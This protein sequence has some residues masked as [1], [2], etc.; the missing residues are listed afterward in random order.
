MRIALATP[1]IMRTNRDKRL[2]LEF[3][4]ARVT[5]FRVE[6]FSWGYETSVLGGAAHGSDAAGCLRASE[7]A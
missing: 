5:S 1:R 2:R 6:G 4:G 3:D 7:R